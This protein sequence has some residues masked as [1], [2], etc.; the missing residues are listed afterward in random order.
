[1]SRNN[2]IIAALAGAAA[3][4]L[5]ANYLGTERGKELLNTATDTLKDLTGKATEFAKNNMPGVKTTDQE[6]ATVA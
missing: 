2:V 3:A 4:A 1:M 6:K 5:I